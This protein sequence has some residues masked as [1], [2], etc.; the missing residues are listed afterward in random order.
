MGYTH[1]SKPVGVDGLYIGA[2]GSETQVGF[3]SGGLAETVTYSFFSNTAGAAGTG[4][5]ITPW[6][7]TISAKVCSTASDGSARN[8]TIT[9]CS[10]GSGGAVIL[11]SPTV[12]ITS[13]TTAFV[14]VGQAM[15]VSAGSTACVAGTLYRVACPAVAEGTAQVI[16]C[17]VTVT[18]T[19]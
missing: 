12:F 7:G 2:K 18:R 19:A 16:A 1:Y 8:V 11:A 6:A 5:F 3:S 14:D 4:Y 13:Q 15:I 17:I 10:A 9:N